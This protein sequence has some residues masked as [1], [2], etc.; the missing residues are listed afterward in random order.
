MLIPPKVTHY[1]DPGSGHFHNNAFD[2][3]FNKKHKLS[4]FNIATVSTSGN[5]LAAGLNLPKR[6]I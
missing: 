5:C 4:L 1:P 2:R 3:N 6:R